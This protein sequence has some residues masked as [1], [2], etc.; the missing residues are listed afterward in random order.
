MGSY[1][2]KRTRFHSAKYRSASEHRNYQARL[3]ADEQQKA[4]LAAKNGHADQFFQ[5]YFFNRQKKAY[6]HPL[7]ELPIASPTMADAQ[8]LNDEVDMYLYRANA[9]Q[10]FKLTSDMLDNLTLK[11]IPS[12]CI[13]PPRS[14]PE[15]VIGEKVFDS[16]KIDSKNLDEFL[17]KRLQEHKF[18]DLYVGD[19]EAMKSKNSLLEDEL[20]E[21]ES[22]ASHPKISSVYLLETETQ[23]QLH[24]LYERYSPRNID[25]YRNLYKEIRKDFHSKSSKTLGEEEKASI[26]KEKSFFRIQQGVNYAQYKKIK[27]MRRLRKMNEI[28]RREKEKQMMREKAESE[29]KAREAAYQAAKI[30]A[31]EKSKMSSTNMEGLNRMGNIQGN[32]PSSIPTNMPTNMPA[33]MPA[34]IPANI[35][36][37]NASIANPAKPAGKSDKSKPDDALNE[38]FGENTGGFDFGNLYGNGDDDFDLNNGNNNVGGEFGEL[39]EHMFLDNLE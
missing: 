5:R 34:N 14:F 28:R 11:A 26:K 22:D 30:Q 24:K 4:A 17:K 31:E 25:E 6:G 39:N 16:S 33:N 20:K 13:V 8:Y 9:M 21:L 38:L 18:S 27:Q 3:R 2:K 19:L 29:K 37:A 12:H 10:K 1:K 36:V 23:D 15:S 32:L 35:P 7:F